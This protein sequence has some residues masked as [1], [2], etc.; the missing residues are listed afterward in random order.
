MKIGYGI[1]F[2][3]LTLVKLFSTNSLL[4]NLPDKVT[5]SK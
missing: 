5:Y 4:T 2:R 1:L 3:T